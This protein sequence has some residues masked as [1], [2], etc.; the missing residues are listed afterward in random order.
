MGYWGDVEDVGGAWEIRW[1]NWRFC[2]MGKELQQT[3]QQLLDAQQRAYHPEASIR[4]YQD[5]VVSSDPEIP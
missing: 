3:V 1:I 5:P 2:I 4:V